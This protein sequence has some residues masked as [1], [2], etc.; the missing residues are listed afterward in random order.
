VAEGD[1]IELDVPAR[2]IELRVSEEELARRRSAW[3]PRE[4]PYARGWVALY[5]RHV[6]QAD[7]GCDFDL[8]E[9]TAPLP[10][11]AIH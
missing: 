3:K 8:L 2:K 7:K 10:E 4:L 5:A 6:R 1:L 9:G 11:P